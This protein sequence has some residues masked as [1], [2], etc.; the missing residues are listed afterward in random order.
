MQAIGGIPRGVLIA[1]ND[2][3]DNC[4]EIK[5]GQEVVLLAHM[6][7]I[8][9]GENLVDPQVIAWLQAG[10]QYRGANASVLWIDE[11]VKPHAW[12]IP[13]V[14]QAALEACDVFISHSFD[15]TNEEFGFSAK[16]RERGHRLT[17]VRNFATTPS[18]LST[19]WAQ[20]PYELVTQIR[21][22]AAT[23]FQEG[24]PFRLTDDNGTCLEGTIA[25]SRFGYYT[26]GRKDVSTYL[27]F[28][29]VAVSPNQYYGY[30][31]SFYL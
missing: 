23:A 12:R 16:A 10:I 25:P 30:V 4:A 5:A 18:L 7:G 31:W 22:Q 6:D 14:F 26:S 1:V 21:Y 24:K 27:P 3:L 13:P 29:G 11:P 8:Y 2:L 28:P 9:G 15:L 20:T 17:F 19:A